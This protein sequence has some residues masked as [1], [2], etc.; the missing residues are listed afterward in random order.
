MQFHLVL[1]FLHTH[2]TVPNISSWFCLFVSFGLHPW[3]VEV[4][5]PRME[6][7]HGR[8][9]SHSCDNVRSLIC[10]AAGELQELI[11]FL[12]VFAE[13]NTCVCLHKPNLRLGF[14]YFFLKKFFF[15]S[16]FL[17]Y[18]I[19]CPTFGYGAFE[20]LYSQMSSFSSLFFCYCVIQRKTFLT[21]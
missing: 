14:V 7:M 9:P 3:H 10:C 2:N 15:G 18:F 1:S 12:K 17:P 21:E 5:R 16:C 6:P 13:F 19:F 20:F 8:A 11:F 4:S